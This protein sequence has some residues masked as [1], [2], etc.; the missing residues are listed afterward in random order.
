MG[1]RRAPLT[2]FLAEATILSDEGLEPAVEWTEVTLTCT[3]TL[4]TF[5]GSTL[6]S[7]R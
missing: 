4:T 1:H 3:R 2:S 7:L 5:E 6:T